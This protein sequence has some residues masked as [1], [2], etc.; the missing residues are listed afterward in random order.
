MTEL[1]SNMLHLKKFNQSLSGLESEKSTSFTFDCS[2]LSGKTILAYIPSVNYAGYAE[3]DY[4]IGATN[5]L[6]AIGIWVTSRA[7]ATLTYGS[8]ALY[9]LYTD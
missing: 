6:S 2:S 5:D 1:Y 9:V 4:K 7:T 3:M 8:V